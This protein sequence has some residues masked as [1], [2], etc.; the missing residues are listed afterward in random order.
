MLCCHFGSANA[1]L[2][3]VIIE[4]VFSCFHCI[5]LCNYV[6][7][8]PVQYQLW[9]PRLDIS[10]HVTFLFYNKLL[11]LLKKK[12]GSVGRRKK[13]TS[14]FL[15]DCVTLM[16]YLSKYKPASCERITRQLRGAHKYTTKFFEDMMSVYPRMILTLTKASV[17]FQF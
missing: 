6:S 10:S 3:L 13:G 14:P 9:D 5:F 17:S 2:R 8:V 4:I 16:L 12:T 1:T 15:D 7:R 11:L